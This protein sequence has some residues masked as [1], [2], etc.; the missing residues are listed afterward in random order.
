MRVLDGEYVE[1]R[2]DSLQISRTVAL[3]AAGGPM[4]PPA[5]WFTNPEFDR[6]MPITVTADGRIHGHIAAWRTD[7][8]GMPS[9]TKPP[10]SA[11]DYAYFRT[12]VLRTDDGKD[13]QVGQLT[14]AGGHAPITAGADEAVKHYDDTS[15]SVADITVGED[16][17]GIWITGGVRPG[18]TDEQIRALRAS[19]PSGDWRPIEVAPGLR[20]LELVAVCQV[21]TP[22]F[23]IARAMVAAG[24]LT[25]LVAAGAGYMYGLQQEQSVYQE[26]A[27]QREQLTALEALVAGL[28]GKK[29]DE[30]ESEYEDESDKSETED[31]ADKPAPHGDKDK[32]QE[33]MRM[34][35][36]FRDRARRKS[37]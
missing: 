3:T 22:G 26:L 18:V 24:E 1:V 29:K 12:G 31:E 25:A 5:E 19:A 34:R 8:I 13:V 6:P 10:R 35:K 9:N 16:E 11:T 2:D 21:N 36:D 15:S 14:L 27:R 30:S 33:R 20:S 4:F 7:H 28:V 17:H 23:P 32:E 37:K